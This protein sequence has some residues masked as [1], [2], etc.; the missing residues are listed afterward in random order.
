MCCSGLPQTPVSGEGAL[1]VF[2]PGG[3]PVVVRKGL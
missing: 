1:A 2:E 3:F